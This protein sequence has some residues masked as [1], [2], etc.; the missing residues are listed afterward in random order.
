MK[1]TKK[2]AE[3]RVY[4]LNGCYRTVIGVT[5]KNWES[6]R[7]S[8]KKNWVV[9]FRYFDPA[10]RD[11]YPHGKPVFT[12]GMNEFK[13]L[14]ERQ[15]ATKKVIQGQIALIDRHNYNPIT[16]KVNVAATVVEEKKKIVSRNSFLAESLSYACEN[17]SMAKNTRDDIRNKIPHIVQAASQLHFDVSTE[18]ISI[19]NPG[20]PSLTGVFLD[21]YPVGKLQRLHIRAIL[22]QIGRNKGKKKWTNNNF[23]SYKKDLGI[24]FL[25]LEES[26]VIKENPVDGIRKR[27]VIS[28]GREVISK[29]H[30]IQITDYL[31]KNHYTFWR[32]AKIFQCS[33]TRETE[34]MR[35]QVKDVHIEKRGF[36]A[37][38]LKDGVY[39]K[40]WK[41][42]ES[43]VL[44]L[45][46]ELLSE[47]PVEGNGEYFVFS[48]GL[49]PGVK[50]IRED[51]I[52]KRWYRLV[53]NNKKLHQ[54]SIYCNEDFYTFKHFNST[55]I[56]DKEAERIVN[57]AIGRG[58][59]K[60][61]KKNSHTTTRMV[62]T[63][64]DINQEERRSR[65]IRKVKKAL[66]KK[67]VGRKKL[68]LRTASAHPTE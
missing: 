43:S 34:F 9:W 59:Q 31:L 52:T 47:Y 15:E 44:H 61:A 46:I 49:K 39:T 65:L 35:L 25:E 1:S 22:D 12:A 17:R 64:Y 18:E 20:T 24:L 19:E 7:A 33:G 37:L 27:K 36:W 8:T 32:F 23:N 63:V 3:E 57:E 38:N 50:P 4:L 41:E 55:S 2:N 56:V 58:Q 40:V 54:Q 6:Q 67:Q 14:A 10:F 62:E 68:V 66:L 5:P 16:G 11:K 28:G 48:R 60:A 45:W 26:G 53:K 13:T 42:I 21:K 30:A 51:Q 29:E